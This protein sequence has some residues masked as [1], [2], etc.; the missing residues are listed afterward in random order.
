VASESRTE[1]VDSCIDQRNRAA[2]PFCNLGRLQAF[3]AEQPEDDGGECLSRVL[4]VEGH[5][6][7][8]KLAGFPPLPAPRAREGVGSLDCTIMQ[9]SEKL[10]GQNYWDAT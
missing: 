2:A 3:D 5:G 7:C 1:L 4:Q 6:G 9:G 8:E 10:P